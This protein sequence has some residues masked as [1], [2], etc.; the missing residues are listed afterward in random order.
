MR[1]AVVCAFIASV[2]MSVGRNLLS[3]SVSRFSFGTAAFFGV[4]AIL[5]TSGFAGL[6]VPS[7]INYRGISVMTLVQSLI[8]AALLI[9][10]Q[11]S[12]TIALGRGNTALC[13][14]VYSLGFVLPAVSGALFWNEEF[15][16][17]NFFGLIFAVL[18]I[19]FSK[20]GKEKGAGKGGFLPLI[21]SAA[22]S[23][24]LGI[25][26]K[27]QQNS[28]VSD[29]KSMFI[30][31]AFLLS[32]CISY[33]SG[34]LS[35]SEKEHR[36]SGRE[37]LCAA[38]TGICFGCCNLLNTFLAGR[39]SSAFFFPVQNVSVIV[40]SLAAGLILFH[41]RFGKREAAVVLA[42]ICAV[43]MNR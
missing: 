2:T 12:Y 21:I 5:F 9:T 39:L 31:T 17:K 11:W 42:G 25:M 10:A 40:L 29:Q 3:K 4:Q 41:E 37:K 20:Y 15:T 30:L 8:Y 28:P 24:G 27:L 33:I 19:V 18:A 26:Q 7:L 38:V 43:I 35:R 34:R 32:G 22:A 13:V 1:Y 36:L 16:Q 23:G 6:L 14:T